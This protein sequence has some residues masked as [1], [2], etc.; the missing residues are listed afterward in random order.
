MHH[1]FETLAAE[2]RFTGAP[3]ATTAARLGLRIAGR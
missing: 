3:S 1:R 2:F